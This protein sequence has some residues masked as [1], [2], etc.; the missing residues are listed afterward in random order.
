MKSIFDW[1]KNIKTHYIKIEV[2][3]EIFNEIYVT[4][5][6]EVGGGGVCHP[7]PPPVSA[8]VLV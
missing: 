3:G 5:G 1:V 2:T 4:F 6:V 7:L 8:P